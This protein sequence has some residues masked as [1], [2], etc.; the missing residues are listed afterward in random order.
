[1]VLLVPVRITSYI[2]GL[3]SLLLLAPLEHLLKEVELCGGRG[4]QEDGGEEG[5]EDACHCCF[6]QRLCNSRFGLWIRI[7]NTWKRSHER[8]ED[9][10]LQ[11]KGS[12][13]RI[14]GVVEG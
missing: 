10:K 6:R 1:M 4:D 2:L 5:E 11:R 14:K 12:C 7:A 3:M 9:V 8:K 13:G